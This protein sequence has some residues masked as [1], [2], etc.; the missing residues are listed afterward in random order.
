MI[1]SSQTRLIRLT[2]PLL[3]SIVLLG[4]VLSL[5]ADLDIDL[6]TLQGM[7]NAIPGKT[8][9]LEICSEVGKL[10]EDRMKNQFPCWAEVW[11]D[12]EDSREQVSQALMLA[13][14]EVL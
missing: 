3:H 12:E 4:F 14:E 11:P 6:P 7:L 9:V 10:F 8:Q 2:F 5:P 1:I 13:L